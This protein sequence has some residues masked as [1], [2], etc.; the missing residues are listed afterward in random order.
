MP[1]IQ[2]IEDQK[3]GTT[4]KALEF[5]S[6]YYDIQRNKNVYPQRGFPIALNNLRNDIPKDKLKADEFICKLL[7]D[8][9]IRKSV[10]ELGLFD[11]AL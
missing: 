5:L 9:Q 6:C 1:L 3:D 8:P 2:A 4:S 11:N 7:N 10:G